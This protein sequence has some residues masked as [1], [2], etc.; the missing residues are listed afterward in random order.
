VSWIGTTPAANLR[1]VREA[2]K[3]RVDEFINDWLTANPK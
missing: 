1:D 3:D 2:V